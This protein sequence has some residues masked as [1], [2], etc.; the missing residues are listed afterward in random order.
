MIV[1]P[2]TPLLSR[3]LGWIAVLTGI[4]ACGDLSDSM[5]TPFDTSIDSVP[6]RQAIST[7]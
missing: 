3:S 6:V 7:L 2:V 5:N 4:V 1:N